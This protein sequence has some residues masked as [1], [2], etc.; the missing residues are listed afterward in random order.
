MS[1]LG[2]AC[3]VLT[4]GFAHPLTSSLLQVLEAIHHPYWARDESAIQTEMLDVVRRWLGGLEQLKRSLIISSLSKDSVRAG[5]NKREDSASYG[6]LGHRCGASGGHGHAQH[7]PGSGS[8]YTQGALGT[9]GSQHHQTL[10]TGNRISGNPFPQQSS[11]YGQQ[12][13]QYGQHGGQSQNRYGSAQHEQGSYGSS[14][15]AGQAGTIGGAFAGMAN[16]FERPAAQT[17]NRPSGY[18]GSGG[19]RHDDDDESRHTGYGGRASGENTYG[20]P[21]F[22][23][24]STPS[25]GRHEQPGQQQHTFGSPAYGQASSENRYGQSDSQDRPSYGQQFGGRRNNDEDNDRRHGQPEYGR[26][27][28]YEGD[29]ERRDNRRHEHSGQGYGQPQE[30]AYGRDDQPAYGRSEGGRRHNNDDDDDNVRRS[31]NR[32]GTGQQEGRATYGGGD[33]YRQGG[34]RRDEDDGDRTGASQFGRMNLGEG[35]DN[36]RNDND[37]ERNDRHRNQGLGEQ[38]H[39]YGGRRNDD[40]S[41]NDRFQNQGYGEQSHGYGGRR[42]NDDDNDYE[43]RNRYGESRSVSGTLAARYLQ[44]GPK[45]NR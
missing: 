44:A 33:D 13:S 32:F 22:E 21:S 30:H 11:Q 5:N 43:R 36:R 12:S 25:Y 40:E 37:D 1:S 42:N 19:R 38:T 35:R 29:D 15:G 20:R 4:P 3:P 6:T 2:S 8:A 28:Q 26:Q 39:A 45:D 16:R 14:S 34:R 27:H 23:Q 9:G 31:G 17:E 7:A 41:S 18:G 10:A 24:D